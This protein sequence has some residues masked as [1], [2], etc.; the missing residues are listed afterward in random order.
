M[1]RQNR[2]TIEDVAKLSGVSTGTVSR[3]LNGSLNV[4]PA[5]RQ[6][7]LDVIERL[8][9]QPSVH[10]RRTAGAKAYTVSVILPM[11]ETEFYA[12]LVEGIERKLRSQWHVPVISPVFSRERVASLRQPNIPAYDADGIIL[13]SLLPER[14]YPSGHFPTAR[15]AVLVDSYSPAYD[16]VYLDNEYGGYL[17]GR[18]LAQYK[19]DIHV[20]SVQE[21][22]ESPLAGV[23]RHRLQG[24]RRALEEA[25]RELPDDHVHAY[26]FSW[27]AGCLAT[28]DI[29]QRSKPPVN[30]FALC[31]LLALGVIEEA[32]RASLDLGKAVRVIGF[33]DHSWTAELG[34]TTVHQDIEEMGEAAAG[35]LLE[36]L[37]G[38]K[39]PVREVR[40]TPRLVVRKSA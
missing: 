24:F 25:G 23:F 7:V 30:I 3:V 26:D 1:A 4:R 22:A 20:I 13:C 18:R 15:P 32:A 39:S 12:R 27:S 37:N 29:L 34:L 40:F 2:V 9:Y 38:D 28:R 19:G 33:D 17:A 11:I 10:A 8:K 35:L 31:D 21:Y 16:S 36:R 14:L 6:Q 5:T